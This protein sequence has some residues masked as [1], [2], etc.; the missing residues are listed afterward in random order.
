MENM[1][2]KHG[3]LRGSI[4]GKS[5]SSRVKLSAK[6]KY[7]GSSDN[8]EYKFDYKPLKLDEP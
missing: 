1:Y 5:S 3:S 7:F 4:G 2:V 6:M 8:L